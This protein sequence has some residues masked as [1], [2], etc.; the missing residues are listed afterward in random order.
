MLEIREEIKK[1]SPHA[2]EVL[3]AEV[4]SKALNKDVSVNISSVDYDSDPCSVSMNMQFSES[5]EP[6]PKG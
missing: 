2:I 6:F 4:L 1:L 3:I 5:F